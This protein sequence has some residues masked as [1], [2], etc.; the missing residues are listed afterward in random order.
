[1]MKT[2]VVMANDFPDAVFLKE[3]GAEAYVEAKI[4]VD[5]KFRERNDRCQQIHYRWYEFEAR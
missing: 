2:Y 5:K 4:A 3:D 1:M